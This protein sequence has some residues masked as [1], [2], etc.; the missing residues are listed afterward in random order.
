MGKRDGAHWEMS[1]RH[2]VLHVGDEWSKDKRNGRAN[3]EQDGYIHPAIQTSVPFDWM[4][5]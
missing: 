5:A 1:I 2:C 3:L 4:D